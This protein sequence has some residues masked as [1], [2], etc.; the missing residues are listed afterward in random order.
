MEYVVDTSVRTV[1]SSLIDSPQLLYFLWYYVILTLRFT[2]SLYRFRAKFA[3]FGDIS[4]VI[5]LLY[6]IV[7]LIILTL[8]S[9]IDRLPG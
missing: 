8:T 9:L 2:I 4:F 7:L 6:T 5:V 3:R 1:Q